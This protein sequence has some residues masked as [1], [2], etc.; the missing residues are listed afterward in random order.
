MLQ[1][2]LA[3][4]LEAT[5][6]SEAGWAPAQ[7]AAP[8]VAAEP[9]ALQ[10]EALSS[11]VRMSRAKVPGGWLLATPQGSITFLPDAGH[12]WDGKSLQ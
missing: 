4:P 1:V 11:A 12:Q 7:A 10:F 5:S 6:S 2:A 8:A 3:V 9:P